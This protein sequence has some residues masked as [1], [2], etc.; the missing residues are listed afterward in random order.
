M[1]RTKKE[2]KV[3]ETTQEI[4]ESEE[5]VVE[6]TVETPAEAEETVVAESEAQPEEPQAEETNDNSAKA[7]EKRADVPQDKNVV[8]LRG[9]IRAIRQELDDNGMEQNVL[10]ITTPQPRRDGTVGTERVD[11]IWG[12][13]TRAQGLISDYH[14]GDHVVVYA[15]YRTYI[16][17]D[18][19]RGSN[20]YGE[21]IKKC[22]APGITGMAAFDPD[23]NEGYFVGTIR[24]IN[25]INPNFAIV[26]LVLYSRN[27]RKRVACYP[28]IGI[29]GYVY[30]AFKQNAVRF[31][32]E[33]KK[34]GVS[35]QIVMRFNEQTN[36]K[37]IQ[38]N[39]QG[40]YYFDEEGVAHSIEIRPGRRFVRGQR[41]NVARERRPQIVKSSAAEEL[42]HMT[43]GSGSEE[44]DVV[45]SEAAESLLAPPAAEDGEM[46]EYDKTGEN[47]PRV[48][49]SKE[50]IRKQLMSDAE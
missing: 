19:N 47:A 22:D 9:M 41:N 7:E 2:E 36:M 3:E 11:V 34:L 12:S 48:V 21:T 4:M 42:R 27:R 24:R 29:G 46:I 45:P 40:L 49:A 6:E 18:R 28:S 44:D 35:C 15:E 10:T 17:S 16:D 26:S 31:E 43:G 20:F 13:N 8:Y 5:T 14:A 38:W 25:E 50:D 23:K 39:A 33:G 1:A 32:G 30:R 37:D